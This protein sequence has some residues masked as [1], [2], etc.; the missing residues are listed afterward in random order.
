MCY[1]VMAANEMESDIFYVVWE[2]ALN[3]ELLSWLSRTD[4][5]M[6]ANTLG[7]IWDKSLLMQVSWNKLVTA[8]CPYYL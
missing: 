5:S 1:Q 3:T 2:R 6:V 8:D 7:A 4:A